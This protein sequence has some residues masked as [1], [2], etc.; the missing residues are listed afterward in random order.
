MYGRGQKTERIGAED[1]ISTGRTAPEFNPYLG[2]DNMIDSPPAS[3][4]LRS[5]APEQLP[6]ALGAPCWCFW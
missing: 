4:H 3:T 2:A 1:L 6:P 5:A